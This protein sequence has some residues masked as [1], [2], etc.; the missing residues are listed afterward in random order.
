MAK[1]IEASEELI[2]KRIKRTDGTRDKIVDINTYGYK[3]ESGGRQIPA[4]KV[5]QKG[6]GFIELDKADPAGCYGGEGE[7]E[8][9]PA[10]K[11]RGK[12]APAK[13]RT[14]KT[15]ATRTQKRGGVRR[16]AED[17][18]APKKGRKGAAKGAAAKPKRQASKRQASDETLSVETAGKAASGRKRRTKVVE[19]QPVP[20]F[21]TNI[22]RNLRFAI[23]ASIKECLEGSEYDVV[24]RNDEIESRFNNGPDAE[25][26]TL[27]YPLCRMA[28]D[29]IPTPGSVE[30]P[31][32]EEE[33]LEGIT[34]NEDGT[35]DLTEYL[36]EGEASVLASKF[37]AKAKKDVNIGSFA[38]GHGL[39]HAKSDTLYILAGFNGKAYIVINPE[40]GDVKRLNGSRLVSSFEYIDLNEYF[41]GNASA[42]V[43]AEDE[44]FED[45]VTDELDLDDV[46]AGEEVEDEDDLL[47][48]EDFDEEEED[49][50]ED[51]E[52][53]SEE[54]E[55]FEEE[56]EDDDSEEEEEYEDEE[57][58]EL[59]EF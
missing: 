39:L 35:I 38:V 19:K 21:T 30:L 4:N 24:V 14:R 43:E 59:D 8:E 54:E 42:D 9:K 58:D 55:D 37:E 15:S 18:P 52:D 1:R 22:S 3:V 10:R 7:V 51:L 41:S 44:D 11:T 32:E 28:F 31:E 56:E 16:K 25:D 29:I 46:D 27:E 45:D 57:D 26:T 40:T 34:I 36:S 49:L 50:E 17:A 12:K 23:L 2:G 13:K 53:D 48:D 47:D 20:Q 6:R 5:A 33:E